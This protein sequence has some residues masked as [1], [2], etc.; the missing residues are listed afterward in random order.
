MSDSL[1]SRRDAIAALAS[2]AAL[3]LVPACSARACPPS[4]PAT[5][6]RRRARA[7]RRAVPSN[8]LR[9]FPESATSLGIDT[10][11]RARCAPSSP[12]ARRRAA[13]RRRPAAC[14]PRPG[15]RR[16]HD[17]LSHATRTSVEVV[18][19]AYA[20]ALA[21]FALPYGDIAVGGWRNT[22]YVV[23]QNV[24]AYLDVPRFL[25]SDH[26]IENAADAEAYLA[27]LQSYAKQLDGELGRI[28]AARA[29]GLVPPAFL[30]DKALRQMRLSAKNARDGG[31]LVE[32]IER[33]TKEHPGQL[34]RARA[35]AIA[36]QEIAPA[37]DRQIAELR[38]AAGGR[39]PTTPASGRGR[40]A[41]SST[42][43]RS[44]R[45][46]RRRCRPTRSTRSAA[47][48]CSSLHA[49]MDAILKGLGY[50]QGTVGE[51]MKALAKDPRTS[52][53]RATRAAPRSWRSSRTA[54]SG[55][56]RRCRA[57][58]TRSSIRT[59]R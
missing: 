33:R 15:Q 1:I 17:R 24:G 46:R 57:R 12:T 35:R 19:S 40:A 59:W 36:T 37:L 45:R 20:T 47:A 42:G 31:T 48:S 9:L 49:Q 26:R 14:R 21:G 25:D 30:I 39:R 10:G 28:Q 6:G 3:P 2:T 23:I 11:A 43:G 18:R 41:R 8:L 22:P 4:T 44:R 54:S 16:Q 51:R 56:G 13:A 55:S 7:A 38:G 34:G 32:S 58:S 5:T 53:P 52:S 29:A 27:R 50:S